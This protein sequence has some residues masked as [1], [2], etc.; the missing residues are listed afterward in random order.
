MLNIIYIIRLDKVPSNLIQIQKFDKSKENDA[1]NTYVMY[2]YI[3]NSMHKIT[4]YQCHKVIFIECIAI[5]I[6]FVLFGLF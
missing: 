1:K 5:I 4:Y 6:C 2:V 3:Q